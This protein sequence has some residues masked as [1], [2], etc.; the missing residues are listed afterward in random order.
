MLKGSTLVDVNAAPASVWAVAL[1]SKKAPGLV[2]VGSSNSH[3]STY[4]GGSG[5]LRDV[6]GWA[7]PDAAR[8]LQVQN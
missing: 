5:E 1:G 8:Q 4:D 3:V 2:A 6:V 7:S